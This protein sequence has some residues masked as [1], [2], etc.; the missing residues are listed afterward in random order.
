MFHYSVKEGLPS[1]EVYKVLQDDFGY[2]WI[3]TD[4]GIS[5]YDG[6]EFSNYSSKDGMSDNVVFDAYK[7][8]NGEIWLLG[9]NKTISI[10]SPNTPYFRKYE[11]NDTIVKYGELTPSRLCVDEEDNL[12]VNFIQ[13]CD[14][15]K[16]DSNGNVLEVPNRDCMNIGVKIRC[17]FQ[18]ADYSVVVEDSSAHDNGFY[19]SMSFPFTGYYTSRSGKSPLGSAIVYKLPDEK[20]QLKLLDGSAIVLEKQQAVDK[21]GFVNANKFWI[22]YRYD[23]IKYFDLQGNETNHYLPEKT[24]TNFF[25]DSEGNQWISTLNDGVYLIPSGEVQKY[26]IPHQKDNYIWDLDVTSQGDL[27]VCFLNGNVSLISGREVKRIVESKNRVPSNAVNM[28]ENSGTYYLTDSDLYVLERNERINDQLTGNANSLLRLSDSTIGYCSYTGFMEL[29]VGGRHKMTNAERKIYRSF[30]TDERIYLASYFGTFFSDRETYDFVPFMGYGKRVND[31]SVIDDFLVLGTNGEGLLV[32]KHDTLVTSYDRSIIGGD[33]ITRI[34]QEN[35]S[36]V[37]V[38]S[39]TGL[40]NI[41]Y[42]SSGT[43]YTLSTT[44]ISEQMPSREVKELISHRDTLWIGTSDGLYY[45]DLIT[46]RKR[47]DDI[48]HHLSIN[49]ISINDELFEDDL[50]ELSYAQNRIVFAFSGISLDPTTELVYRYKLTGAE[51]EWNYTKERKAIYA[52]LSPGD[53]EFIVQLRGEHLNWTREM[54]KV[55]L[56]IHPPFWKSTW[57]LLGI[58]VS[59]ILLIYLFFRFR[60][61]LYNRDL[62]RD[63]L[64]HLSERLRKEEPVLIVREGNKDVKILSNAIYFV[65]SDGNYLEIYHENGKTTVRHKIGE[66]LDMIPDP[67]EYVRL[68]R[69]YIVRIDKVEQKGK[70]EV[71]VNGETIPVGKTYMDELEKI[72]F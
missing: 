68:R 39:N 19:E 12:Y 10:L 23:G 6:Y 9:H 32:F 20:V 34:Y 38:G 41:V 28:G 13:C 14:Q 42:K 52:N 63:I 65:K 64:R 25:S 36:S 71:V 16:I 44:N 47:R 24:V 30:L 70:K 22:S 61:L 59:V 49:E 33:F 60:I 37:W 69:S 1:S 3:L 43:R 2:I 17:P 56:K 57:F 55:P 54:V 31:L 7:R 66:F 18:Q 21:V 15:L 5:R 67:L 50:N 29:G 35:D 45:L 8:E 62:V 26:P 58:T 72:S 4:K 51:E 40:T 27:L 48:E 46:F 11:F 53:Y